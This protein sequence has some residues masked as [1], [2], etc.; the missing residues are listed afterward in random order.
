MPDF[1]LADDAISELPAIL[2]LAPGPP[3]APTAAAN[4]TQCGMF[5]C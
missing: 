4:V 5:A 1:V 2:I 3:D